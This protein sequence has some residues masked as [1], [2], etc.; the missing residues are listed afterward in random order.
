[1]YKRKVVLFV[2]ALLTQWDD[3]IDIKLTPMKKK[4]DGLVTD[5][6]L[7]GL[8]LPKPFLQSSPTVLIECSKKWGTLHH[9]TPP[10]FDCTRPFA[11][12]RFAPVK[13]CESDKDA[14]IG[15]CD[16]GRSAPVDEPTACL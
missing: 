4:V 14:S 9:K 3:V 1:M 2:Q 16:T 15:L 6:A 10:R 13:A 11:D 12:C 5:E 7:A 8:A